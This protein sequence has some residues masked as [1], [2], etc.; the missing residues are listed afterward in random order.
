M[1]TI[2]KKPL[3]ETIMDNLDG[4]TLVKLRSDID[5]DTGYSEYNLLERYLPQLG[6]GETSLAVRATLITNGETLVGSYIKYSSL[7]ETHSYLLNYGR[8]VHKVYIYEINEEKRTTYLV[9]ECLGVSELRR[10]IVDRLIEQGANDIPIHKNEN[11]S[12]VFNEGLEVKSNGDVTVGKN[13][14]V[15]GKVFTLNGKQWGIMP[16]CTDIDNVITNKGY[17][18]YSKKPGIFSPATNITV[19]QCR[20]IY[21]NETGNV[22]IFSYSPSADNISIEND[23]LYIKSNEA[24]TSFFNSA[25]NM[26]LAENEVSQIKNKQNK[27]YRHMITLRAESSANGTCRL[28]WISPSNL[29]CDSLEDLRTVLGNP[30]MN[31]C[32]ASNPSG[33]LFGVVI[34]PSTAQF[35]KVG[36]DSLTNITTVSDNVTTL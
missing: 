9:G 15:A 23:T 17:I 13:L 29:V 27:L 26:E 28:E 2:M 3:I 5:S 36:A 33:D 4:D 6:E 21:L 25:F 8:G 22:Y 32:V 18:I 35:K 11:G 31:S 20:G 10:V 12:Y 24:Y 19:F 30:Q 7:G 1:S 34:S 16:V 14:E